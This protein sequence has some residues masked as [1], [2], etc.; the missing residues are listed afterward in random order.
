MGNL[1]S[2]RVIVTGGGQ[3]IGRAIVEELLRHGC[4]VAIHYCTSAEGAQEAKRLAPTGA[5]V[6]CFQADLE[7]ESAATDLV[8]RSAAFL[9]GLD[10]LINNSGDLVGRRTLEQVDAGFWRKVMDVNLTS[11]MLVT[12]AALPHLVKA[13]QSSIVNIAS[14]AGRMGGHAGSLVYSTAKGAVLTWTRFLA[15]ELGPRG[16]RVNAVA[17]GLILGTR[18]HQTHTTAESAAASIAQI[19]LGRAGTPED[20]ARAVAFLAAEYDGFITGATL[21]IN[22]GVYGS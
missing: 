13:G 19:P 21:D 17:P 18:F 22:G 15:K 9:A 3:G 4:H 5:R 14:L 8:S 16:V 1:L 2:K 6:E 20:V 12:R 7:D 11:L 10:I